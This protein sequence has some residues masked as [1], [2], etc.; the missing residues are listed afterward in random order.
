MGRWFL[1]LLAALV[2]LLRFGCTAHAADATETASIDGMQRGLVSRA[3]VYTCEGL[4]PAWNTATTALSVFGTVNAIG[5][6]GED[7]VE[8]ALGGLVPKNTTSFAGRIPDFV[9]GAE[10]YEVKNVQ[11]LAYTEQIAETEWYASL[12]GKHYTIFTRVNTQ[13]S[14]RLL[15]RAYLRKTIR[16]IQC[17]P[18]IL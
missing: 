9:N 10:W 15:A 16:I 8:A 14:K 6:S 4:I 12:L 5:R 18:N 11:T 7:L 13:I 1:A 3:Y 2:V 17:L